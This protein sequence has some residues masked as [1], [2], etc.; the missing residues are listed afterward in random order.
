MISIPRSI[1]IAVGYHRGAT[2]QYPLVSGAQAFCDKRVGTARKPASA[3]FTL[4]ELMIVVA[5]IGILA[6]VAIPNF[7]DY[8][9]RSKVQSAIA[10]VSNAK[11]NVDIWLTDELATTSLDETIKEASKLP[12]TVT[13]HCDYSTTPNIGVASATLICTIVGGPNGA[14]GK[15]V[16]WTRRTGGGWDCTTTAA[17]KLAG[18]HCV[19]TE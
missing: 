15:L 8:M 19:S 3:G 10:E 18:K 16:T 7:Q 5:I 11:N 12:A 2:V 13:K 17:Q 1:L 4:I 14:A 9:A 6:A